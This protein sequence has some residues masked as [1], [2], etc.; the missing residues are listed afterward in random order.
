MR[1]TVTLEPDVASLLEK[2]MRERG[3]SFK[4]AVNDAIRVGLGPNTRAEFRQGTFAMGFR[5]DVNYDRALAI[6]G[7]LE[8]QELQQKIALGH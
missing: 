1:T 2:V 5:A 4:Q 8:D 3:I 6:A 7:A